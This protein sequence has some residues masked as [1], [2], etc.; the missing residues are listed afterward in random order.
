MSQDVFTRVV[1]HDLYLVNKNGCSEDRNVV[2]DTLVKLITSLQ[3]AVSFVT[4]HVQHYVE[5]C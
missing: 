3:K 4:V 1:V 5:I 2:N